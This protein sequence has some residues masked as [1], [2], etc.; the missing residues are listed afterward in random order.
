M[1]SVDEYLN[2]EMNVEQ[3][4]E[5]HHVDYERRVVLTTLSFQEGAMTCGLPILEILSDN[6]TLQS[7]IGMNS[8]LLYAMS[9]QLKVQHA[10]NNLLIES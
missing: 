4:F 5:C 6:I 2:W 10:S 7:D 3:I 9:N 1:T 8:A